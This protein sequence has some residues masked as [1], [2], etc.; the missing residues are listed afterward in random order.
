MPPVVY[1]AQTDPGEI[2]VYFDSFLVGRIVEPY[3]YK[4]GGD[5]YISSIGPTGEA[6][7][8]P[9]TPSVKTATVEILTA[10][11]EYCYLRH[12]IKCTVGFDGSNQR[13]RHIS[14]C[15][16]CEAGGISYAPHAYASKEEALRFML[17]DHHTKTGMPAEIVD[18]PAALPR[19]APPTNSS[20]FRAPHTY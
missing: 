19:D 18:D 7:P 16:T 14:W 3:D 6:F 12:Q 17:L 10:A 8:L 13:E 1:S 20:T 4:P 15:P 2:L 5:L 11:D 9:E